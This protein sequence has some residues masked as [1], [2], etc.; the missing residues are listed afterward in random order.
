MYSLTTYTIPASGSQ[1]VY[2]PIFRS[3]ITDNE[4]MSAGLLGPIVIRV[5]W[6]GSTWANPGYVSPPIRIASFDLITGTTS[7]DPSRAQAMVSRYM[8]GPRTD[9]RYAVPQFQRTVEALTGGMPFTLRMSGVQ[10]LVTSISVLIR[11]LAQSAYTP[12]PLK[13]LDLLDASGASLLG[14]ICGCYL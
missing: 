5:W 4:I 2:L 12:Q 13:Q 10:G 1:T 14:F 9:I 11:D 8:T 7:W 3:C 6:R